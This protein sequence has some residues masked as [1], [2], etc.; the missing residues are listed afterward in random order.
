MPKRQHAYPPTV[1]EAAELLGAEIRRARLARVPLPGFPVQDLRNPKSPLGRVLFWVTQWLDT[2]AK[3]AV[4][5][6]IRKLR[7]DAEA[8][9]ARSWDLYWD[10]FYSDD[11][12]KD[13]AKQLQKE[14]LDQAVRKLNGQQHSDGIGSLTYFCIGQITRRY[15]LPPG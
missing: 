4:T 11:D 8:L 7:G 6:E 5:S 13:E 12:L 10:Y 3:R 2:G 15:V 1:H 9:V 14:L